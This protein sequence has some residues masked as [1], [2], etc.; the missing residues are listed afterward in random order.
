MPLI[1]VDF[2]IDPSGRL[3]ATPTAS[4]GKQA[5]KEDFAGFTPVIQHFHMNP[6]PPSELI[7]DGEPVAGPLSTDCGP[8][9]VVAGPLWGDWDSDEIKA[10]TLAINRVRQICMD[11]CTGGCADTKKCVFL[12]TKTAGPDVESRVNPQNNVVE[13]RAKARASGKCQCE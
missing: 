6:C 3:T 4:A 12:A 2:G 7:G 10:R 5:T 11:Q 8:A 13:F 9:E 1:N